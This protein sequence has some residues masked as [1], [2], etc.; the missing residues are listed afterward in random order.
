MTYFE[1]H[2]LPLVQLK[3]QRRELV[4]ALM[5]CK[6]PIS[7][8][9]IT[10]IALLQHTIAAMEAVIVD[11]DAERAGFGLSLERVI[12]RQRAA[13]GGSGSCPEECRHSTTGIWLAPAPLIVRHD[14]CDGCK[15]CD[16]GRG[17]SERDRK[18]SDP[19]PDHQVSSRRLSRTRARV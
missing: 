1:D 12:S 11:L 14:P 17:Y 8:G 3:E 9:Q 15:R 19:I 6:D 5:G 10:Q 13:P 2:G 16:K 18:Q 7:R 4:V